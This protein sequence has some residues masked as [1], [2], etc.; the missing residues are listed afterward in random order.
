MRIAILTVSDGVASGSREDSSGPAIRDWVVKRGDSIAAER[1]VPDDMGTIAGVIAGWAD[2]GSADVVLTTGGTGLAPRDVTPEA[3]RQVIERI[4]PGIAEALRFTA[5]P[6][7]PTAALS[8]GV[9]GV[10][11]SSL[12][13]NLPGSPRAVREGLEVLDQILN[14]AVAVL[15]G[16]TT[17]HENA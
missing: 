1:V 7:V 13:I 10:R 11:G 4:A 6:R 17:L 16:E 8:R 2:A 9:A 12:I 15:R 14:H 3:T 5:F